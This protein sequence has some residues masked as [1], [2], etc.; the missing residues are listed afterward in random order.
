MT[1][2]ANVLNRTLYLICVFNNLQRSQQI[3]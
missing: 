2:I 1:M 3:N